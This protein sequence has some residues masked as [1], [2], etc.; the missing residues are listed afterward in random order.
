[1]SDVHFVGTSSDD[2]IM[3]RT[4]GPHD[5]LVLSAWFGAHMKNSENNPLV[6]VVV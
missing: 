3:V 5:V 6:S 4:V 2:L 1:M